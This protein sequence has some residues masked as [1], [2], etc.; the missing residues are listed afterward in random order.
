MEYLFVTFVK[1]VWEV[2]FDF[3]VLIEFE[4]LQ[5]TFINKYILSSCYYLTS[6]LSILD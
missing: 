6:K 1:A 5:Q 4:I 2:L 3:I